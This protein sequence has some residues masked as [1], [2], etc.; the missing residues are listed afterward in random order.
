MKKINHFINDWPPGTVYLSAWLKQRGISGQLLNRYKQSGWIQS[1]GSGA[2]K[3]V[4]DHVGYQGALYALQFQRNSS[5]HVGGKSALELQGR[6]HYLKLKTTA[7]C[8]FGDWKEHL[9]LWFSNTDWDIPIDYH[10]TSFFPNNFELVEFEVKN[11]AIKISS[12][13]R[14]ILECLYLAP[15]QQDLME[16]YELMQGLNNLRPTQVQKALETCE[17]IRVKRL[18]AFMAKKAEH[19]WFKHLDLSKINFG[20]GKRSIVQG[21]QFDP[22]YQITLPKELT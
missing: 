14:A 5:I 1:V 22:K 20:S 8:L 9:P 2:V 3:R 16:C 10:R 6:L 18:F 17:S 12:P 11:F 15:E 13:L 19:A 4:G 21:G 7:V